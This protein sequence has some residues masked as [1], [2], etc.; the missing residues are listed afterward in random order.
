MSSWIMGGVH[1]QRKKFYN[2]VEGCLNSN[3]S[4]LT[5]VSS[6]YTLCKVQ[7]LRDIKVIKI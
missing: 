7:C 6:T 1:P 2:L 4:N 3:I 5:N